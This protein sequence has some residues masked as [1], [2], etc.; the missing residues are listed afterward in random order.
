MS[1]NIFGDPLG[2]SEWPYL[3]TQNAWCGAAEQQHWLD[4]LIGPHQYS[5]VDLAKALQRIHEVNQAKLLEEWAARVAL[6][7]DVAMQVA[8]MRCQ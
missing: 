8:D 1:T 7:D 5:F 4:F 6:I 3:F 2:Y